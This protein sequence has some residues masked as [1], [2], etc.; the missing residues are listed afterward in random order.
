MALDMAE[1]LSLQEVLSEALNTKAIILIAHERPR[2]GLTLLRY[3]LEVALE[4]DKPSA[5]LRAYYNLADSLARGDRFEEGAETARDGLALARRV[6]NR[7]LEWSFMAQMYAPFALGEWDE[8]LA[9]RS[10]LPS[11]WA[12]ST[13]RRSCSPSLTRFRRVVRHSSCRRW[14]RDSGRLS[15]PGAETPRRW[16]G[17]SSRRLDGFGSCRFPS[18]SR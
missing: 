2:E 16:S 10:G 9:M 12:T 15:R 6:G 3:A 17:C 14:R 1:A 5:A 11:S 4:H 7:Y 18:T 13:R 8:V